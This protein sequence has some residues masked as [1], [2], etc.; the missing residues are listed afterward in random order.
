RGVWP[1]VLPACAQ[2]CG[3]KGAIMSSVEQI[4][5]SISHALLYPKSIALVGVSDDP[6]KTGGRPLQFLRNTGYA[7]KI[8]PINP[9]RAQV[10][11]EKAW[12]SLGDLPEVPEHV[13]V[14]SPT[15]T[16]VQ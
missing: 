16:V 11:G 3:M 7:G 15:D 4:E 10:Q 5:P 1:V 13:F 6:G 8:Y 12:S 9:K 14:L 2:T